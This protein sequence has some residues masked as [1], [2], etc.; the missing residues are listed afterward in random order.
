[1][2]KHFNKKAELMASIP[3]GSFNSA[4]NFTGSKHI[5]AA[6]TKS[7]SVDGFVIPLAKFQLTKSSWVLQEN[8]IRAI[9]VLWDPPSLARYERLLNCCFGWYKKL[10]GCVL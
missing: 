4:F 2:V 9:P 8:V 1:M 10:P 5:D 7:L 3:L 6:S